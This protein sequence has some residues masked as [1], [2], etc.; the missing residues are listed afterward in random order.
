MKALHVTR[1]YASPLG[2]SK[3]GQVDDNHHGMF[4]RAHRKG[5]CSHRRR[6]YGSPL[7]CKNEGRRGQDQDTQPPPSHGLLWRVWFVHTLP[8]ENYRVGLL[9][10]FIFHIGDTVQFAEFIE[11]NIRLYHIRNLYPL[12]PQ[13]AASWIRRSLAESLRSRSPYT[14]N[15]LI[16]G[17]DTAE[18]LPHLYWVDY[19]GTMASVPFAAHGYGSYFALGLLDR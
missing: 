18:N 16:G 13:S 2:Q 11:R 8:S 15:L 1:D 5:L 19:L 12:R 7:D 6:H 9:P 14:V 17:F 10:Q 4:I 3:Q